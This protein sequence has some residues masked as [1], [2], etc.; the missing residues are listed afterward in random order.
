MKTLNTLK[1][2]TTAALTA[3]SL[4]TGAAYA[5]VAANKAL[6]GQALKELF[7]DKDLSAIDKYWG[8]VYIQHNENVPSGTEALKGLVTPDLNAIPFRMIG[9]GDLVATHSEYTGFGPVPLI[10]FDIFRIEDGKIVEHWDNMIPKAEP[11]PSGHTQT[12]GATEITDLDKT[13]ENK[14]LVVDFVTKVLMNGENVDITKY[15]NPTSYTQHNPLVADGLDGLGAFLAELGKQGISMKYNKIH[16]VVGEGNF[17]LT[18][19]D[20]V[21]GDQPMAFYDLF[22]VEDGLIVEH[23]DVIADMPGSDAPHNEDGKF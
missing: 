10:A 9:D 6:V 14:A 2:T 17:V 5:D 1:K 15:I 21:F 16:L 13:E 3:A 4:F 12:D 20:G 19:S 22:R 8:D 23:W 11:N 18:A 7:A